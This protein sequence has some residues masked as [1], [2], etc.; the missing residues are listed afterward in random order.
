MD[1][2]RRIESTLTWTLESSVINLT[3]YLFLS[4]FY[5]LFIR[6]T[7]DGEIY[8]FNFKTGES[9]WDHPCDKYY[10]NLYDEEKRKDQLKVK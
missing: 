1:S 8:Y 9:V 3:F 10:K 7:E 6:Q 4:T 5:S 2:K